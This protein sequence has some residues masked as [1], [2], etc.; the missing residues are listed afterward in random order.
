LLESRTLLSTWTVNSLGD[1]GTG[2]GMAG[3]L[4]FVI[5]QVDKTTGNN[6]I[7]I[8]HPKPER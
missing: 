5:T 3:D 6:T 7:V 4:R 1:T 2:T 8:R